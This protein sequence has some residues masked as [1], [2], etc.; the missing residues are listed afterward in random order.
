MTNPFFQ[1]EVDLLKNLAAEFAS[2]N[3]ALA[4]LLGQPGSDPDVERLLEGVAF[5]NALLRRKL[6]HDFPELVHTLVQLILPHYLRPAPATTIIGFTA[7]GMRGGPVTIP[8]GTQ[9]A[10]APVDGTLCHFTTTAAVEV[11]PL[12]LTDATFLQRPSCRGELRLSLALCG[13]PLAEWHPGSLRLFLS[14]DHATAAA[15]FLLLSRQL[16]RVVV[17]PADGGSGVVLPGNCLA[18]AGF[19]LDEPLLP[20]P[21][22][23]YPGYRLLQEYFNMPQKFLYFELS[24][25]EQWQQRGSGAR[26]TITFEIDNVASKPPPVRRENFLLNAVAAVNLFPVEAE[27]VSIS[28]RTSRIPI[29]PSGL[30]PGHCRIFS[31]DRVTGYSRAGG[32]RE[33]LPLELFGGDSSSTPLYHAQPLQSSRHGGYDLHLC[34]SFPG[35]LPSPRSESLSVALTC[36]NGG[37]P[38]KL[39]MGDINQPL[40]PLPDFISA[41][42]ITAIHPGLDPPVGAGLLRQLISHLALNHLSIR[43][44]DQLQ[45]L[46]KL[47]VFPGPGG[48]PNEAANL[49]RIAGIESMEVRESEQLVKGVILMGRDIR[50][51]LRQDH[52]AGAGDMYLFGCVLDQ[53]LGRY[54]ALNCYTRLEVVDPLTGASWQWP[55]RL[56]NRQLI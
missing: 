49:K 33:Y 34:L 53:F 41:R 19:D 9:F 47:Y 22:H 3:P 30:D 1:A 7:D 46:L 21:P 31:V 17:T 15:L 37:S 8:A 38:E 4:P 35:G 55:P 50:L 39:R 51:M 26:F 44:A 20:Y 12:E 48:G 27:P 54:A 42:N 2:A 23:A 13:V 18:P 25:W 40:S 10:S 6:K 28:H 14:G 43:R 45:A 56:G 11:H 29:R 36:T 52:F 5:Q 24:G 16:A 32:K